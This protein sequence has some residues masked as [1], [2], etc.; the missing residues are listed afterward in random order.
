ME[1]LHPEYAAI[2]GIILNL[3]LEICKAHGI[4]VDASTQ[5]DLTI[6]IMW[7]VIRISRKVDPPATEDLQKQIAKNIDSGKP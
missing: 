1:N 7:V 5:G 4:D 2:S 3:I 6:L